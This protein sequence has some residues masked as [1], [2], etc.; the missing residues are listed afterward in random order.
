[1]ILIFVNYL[2]TVFCAGETAVTYDYTACAAADA[3]CCT[4]MKTSDPVTSQNTTYWKF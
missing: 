3:A 4:T 1:M 2:S